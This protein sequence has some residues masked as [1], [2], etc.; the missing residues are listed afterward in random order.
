[1]KKVTA[2]VGSARKKNTYRAVE[3]YLDN[4]KTLDDIETEIVVL[5]DYELG[6]CRGCQ[7]CFSKGEAFCP[8][9]DDRDVLFDKIKA[10]DGVIFATPNYTWCMSG[11]MKVFLDR[12]GFVCHRPR[13]FGKAFTSIVL[14]AV[15]RG[16]K[17]VETFDWTANT[18]G[19]NA[20]K[21][22]TITAFDPRTEQQQMK[23]DRDLA[24]HSRRF[25][26]MLEKPA[27]ASPTLFQLFFFRIGRTMIR[28]QADPESIDYHY[29]ADNGWL[30]TDYFYPANMGLLKKAVGAFI[31]RMVPTI[32]KL[33]A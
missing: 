12:F 20:L 29:F 33:F 24:Q 7:L 9:K 6:I 32:Q 17:I 8:L 30:E 13:Y 18:L 27:S 14:Q 15:G 1:M 31:D 28:T 2:F 10:S 19:F 21:G 11:M 4:L 25:Y 16:D 3:Q 5:S 26:T 23:I 22:M